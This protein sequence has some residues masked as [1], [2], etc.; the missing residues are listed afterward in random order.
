[1]H[2]VNGNASLGVTHVCR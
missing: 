1:M 2:E